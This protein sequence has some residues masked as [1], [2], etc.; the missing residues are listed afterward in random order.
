MAKTIDVN[1]PD[2]NTDE[3]KVSKK[4]SY[5]ENWPDGFER[6]SWIMRSEYVKFL[7]QMAQSKGFD[8]YY[9]SLDYVLGEYFKDKKDI[10]DQMKELMK[11]L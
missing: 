4:K 7:K 9:E 6:P 10:M 2:K 8:S 5:G 3:K 11:Q 1:L